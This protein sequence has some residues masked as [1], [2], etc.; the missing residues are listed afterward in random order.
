MGD[1]QESDPAGP[2][3]DPQMKPLRPP[4]GFLGRRRGSA[5]HGGAGTARGPARAGRCARSEGRGRRGAGRARRE[6]RGPGA[7][8]LREGRWRGGPGGGRGGCEGHACRAGGGARRR[9]STVPRTRALAVPVLVSA[10]RGR[11]HP[12]AGPTPAEASVGS[13]PAGSFCL[14][15]EPPWVRASLSSTGVAITQQRV[16]SLLLGRSGAAR[17]GHPATHGPTPPRAVPVAP[18]PCRARARRGRRGP[19]RTK[20]SS[21]SA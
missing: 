7:E 14:P 5:A 20:S 1:V 6:G 15:V 8:G 17:P 13:A 16:V 9:N 18:T 10:Y 3:N 19:S 2:Q 21:C 4:A 12:L 11:S